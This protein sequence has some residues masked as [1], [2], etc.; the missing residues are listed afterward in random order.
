[1]EGFRVGAAMSAATLSAFTAVQSLAGMGLP[2]VDVFNL[3]YSLTSRKA[4]PATQAV[5]TTVNGRTFTTQRLVR[6]VY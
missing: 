1:L 3:A 4:R 6:S 2:W 5:T